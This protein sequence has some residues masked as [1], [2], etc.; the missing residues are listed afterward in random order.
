MPAKP[1]AG[2]GVNVDDDKSEA[3]AV[4]V[5]APVATPVVGSGGSGGSIT[6]PASES[7]YNLP[8]SQMSIS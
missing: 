8:I 3:D 1:K 2:S 7:N 4:I 6:Y 5:A